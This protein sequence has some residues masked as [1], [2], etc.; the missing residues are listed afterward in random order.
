ML[1]D[2][3]D[4]AI[5]VGNTTCNLTGVHFDSPEQDGAEHFGSHEHPL[6][7]QHLDALPK[8]AVVHQA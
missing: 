1:R 3:G 7:Q 8:T 4:S 5:A 2:T 6:T